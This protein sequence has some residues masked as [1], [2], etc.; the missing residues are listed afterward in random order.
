MNHDAF[1][2]RAIDISVNFKYTAKPNPVVGA[3]LVYENEIISEGAHE[4]YGDNHAEV[5]CL[6]GVSRDIIAD[7]TLYC[8]LEPCNHTGKTPPCTEAIISSGLKRIFIGSLDP[9]P[10]VAGSGIARLKDNGIEVKVGIL[11]EKVKESNRFFFFKHLNKRPFI[12][13]K[14]ASSNDGMSH[15]R[16]GSTTWITSEASRQDVQIV[17]AD[18]DAILTGGN[19][20]RNDNPR[21]NARV[22][23]PVNQPG[24]ILLSSVS[25][26]DK[27][28]NFFK[29]GTV[30]VIEN[31]NLESV[32]DELSQMNINSVLVEAGPKLVNS[33]MNNGY[34]DQLIIYESPDSIGNKGI[35]WFEGFNPIDKFQLDLKSTC[36]IDRDIKRV[37]E[38]C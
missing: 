8:T 20:I 27:N 7:S 35:K 5:N 18:H 23:F 16:D 25:E 38:K 13:I 6:N 36:T 14:I 4:Q 11:E 30:K 12:T 29:E 17:R 9:N 19:T 34:F 15:S 33:F 31:S 22:D 1:M 3:I 21:M 37:F 26:W 32:I 24:K 28:L 10:K 2:Q